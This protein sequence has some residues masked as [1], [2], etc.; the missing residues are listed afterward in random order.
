LANV[1]GAVR[2]SSYKHK[3]NRVKQVEGFEFRST[4]AAI[5]VDTYGAQLPRSR[6]RTPDMER[7]AGKHT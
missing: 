6:G 3:Y 7:G 2:Y 1:G 4:S 5:L